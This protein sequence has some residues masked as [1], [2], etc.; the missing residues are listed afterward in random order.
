MRSLRR[1]VSRPLPAD[2]QFD[3]ATLGHLTKDGEAC[4]RQGEISAVEARHGY[5]IWS[6]PQQRART[7]LAHLRVRRE[8]VSTIWLLWIQ[9]NQVVWRGHHQHCVW[10]LEVRRS[11][12]KERCRN[13][14]RRKSSPTAD[15]QQGFQRCYEKVKS[16][17]K[18]K[19]LWRRLA[20]GPVWV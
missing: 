14:I 4:S 7:A 9:E 1:Q 15:P 13:G 3:P 18:A 17:L 8:L 16:L 2:V 6:G 12:N 11:A 19:K 10:L 20:N 5:S